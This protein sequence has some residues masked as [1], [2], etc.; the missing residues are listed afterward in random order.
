MD[1][2]SNEI[3]RRFDQD[4]FSLVAKIEQIILSAGNGQEVVIPEAIHTVYKDLNMTRLAIHLSMLPDI[5]KSYRETTRTPI[6]KVT[7]VCTVCRALNETPGA[8]RL[9]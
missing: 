6:K 3:S 9:C 1:V 5:I 8:K 2:I 7:N 4:D